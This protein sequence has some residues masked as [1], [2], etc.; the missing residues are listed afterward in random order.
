MNRFIKFSWILILLLVSMGAFGQEEE[1]PDIYG[2]GDQTFSISAAVILPLFIHRVD[3]T[4][5]PGFN[6]LSLGATGSLRWGTFLTNELTVGVDVGGMF[7]F[8]TLGRTL[9][10]LPISGIISYAFR[11]YPF[12]LL[13]HGGVG[14]C[15][16]KLDNDLSV[17]PSLM[18]G[19]SF[20]WNYNAE[21]SFGLKTEYWWVPEIFVGDSPPS[22]QTSFGNFLGITLSTLY[23]F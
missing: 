9:V 8:S 15:I 5:T 13:L 18:P 22:S 12:E 3:G 19:F 7:A 11:F 16:I 23:H 17:G 14:V 20:Y 6:Q 4:V 1:T 10:M 21:W 2:L